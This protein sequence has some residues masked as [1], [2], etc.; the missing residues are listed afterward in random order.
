MDTNNDLLRIYNT[1][2]SIKPSYFQTKF[3]FNVVN[4]NKIKLITGKIKIIVKDEIARE[5]AA[6]GGLDDR[7]TSD[8]VDDSSDG[9]DTD[10]HTQSPIIMYG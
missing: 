10:K 4:P 2:N 9:L 1:L 7:S 5:K 6:R 8:P 3:P